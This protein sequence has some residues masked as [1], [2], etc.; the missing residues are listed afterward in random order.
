MRRSLDPGIGHVVA[1]ADPGD[2]FATIF[3]VVLPDGE[4][5]GHHLAGV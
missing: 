1:I 5:I 3:A 2:T 4:D